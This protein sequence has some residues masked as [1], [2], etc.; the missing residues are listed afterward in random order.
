VESQ[1]EAQLGI[2]ADILDG[3]QSAECSTELV[4]SGLVSTRSIQLDNMSA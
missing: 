1:P 3:F 4:G 2:R